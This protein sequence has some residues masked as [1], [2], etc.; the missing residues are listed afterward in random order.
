MTFAR[1]AV[2]L[3]FL[4]IAT[5]A[6]LM[7]AQSDT[8]WQLRAGQEIVAT[9]QVLLR[10]TFTHTVQGSYWPNHEWASEVLF[11][12]LHHLGGMPLLT[13]FAASLVALSWA[14]AWRLMRG[15][16]LL[17]LALV[18][19]VL[20][21]SARLWS[22][23]PQLISLACLALLAWLLVRRRDGWLPLLFLVWAN[24]H[25]GVTLGIAALAGGLAGM[26]WADRSRWRRAAV[27]FGACLA[28]TCLTPLGVTLWTEVPQMLARL[29]AYDV[30]EWRR[31]SLTDPVNAPFWATAAVLMVLTARG[32]RTLDREGAILAGI[33]LALLPLA[34]TSTR[35]ITPFLLVAA[36]A[37]TALLP[38]RAL[39]WAP[40]ARK[41]RAGLNAALFASTAAACLVV[42][43]VGWSRP[44]DRLNWRPI[45]PALARAIGSCP[46]NLYNLYDNGGYLVWFVPGTPVF[47]DS[48]QD[49]FPAAMVA[50]HIRVE[51]TGEYERLFERRAIGCAALP[52]AS[53]VA[54]RLERD[55]W[56]TVGADAR[57]IVMAKGVAG[58]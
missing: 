48:R 1:L 38:S 45:S 22:V 55:G 44:F 42:V 28:A 16:D 31:A 27:L 4:V 13:A 12:L 34:V 53:R 46:G 56:T 24:F 3:L 21:P 15:H 37:I 20:I 18:L 30:Q 25:G 10:D 52:P 6:C 23:R 54:T 36:P 35:N 39:A 47:I 8:Y 26:A 5:V 14:L 49:P 19:A 29:S 33:A 57:W 41:E 9:G 50:D 32:W 11:Y 43:T 58:E 7:P 51:R 2:A 40:R 17:R